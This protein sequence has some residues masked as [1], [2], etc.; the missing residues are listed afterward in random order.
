MVT[1]KGLALIAELIAAA[2]LAIALA[3][4]R[5]RRTAPWLI[6]AV[7]ACAMLLTSVA[8]I[9]GASST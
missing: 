2:W 6:C 4:F 1:L 8:V 9:I 7:V 5:I 3:G